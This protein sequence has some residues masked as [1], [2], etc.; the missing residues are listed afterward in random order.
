MLTLITIRLTSRDGHDDGPYLVF[1]TVLL[2]L[3][4]TLALAT[5]IDLKVGGVLIA[6]N[7]IGWVLALFVNNDGKRDHARHL[8][9]KAP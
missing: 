2:D 5:L 8:N 3:V 6:L 7:I 4:L 1:A 9:R